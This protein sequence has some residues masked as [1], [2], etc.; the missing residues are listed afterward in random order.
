MT[1]AE[2]ADQEALQTRIRQRLG[3]GTGEFDITSSQGP[4]SSSDIEV[5][6]TAGD[7]AALST[8]ADRVLNRV[9]GL[10]SVAQA[11]SDLAASR[12]YVAVEVKARQA[13][14]AGY[15]EA[16]L[17]QLVARQTQ[18]TSIGD[19]TFGDDSLTV[20]LEQQDPP[21]TLA[22]LRRLEVP[23]PTGD[24]R[25]TDLADVRSA[26]SPTAIAT[27]DGARSATV[28]VTPAG[29]DTGAATAAVTAAVREVQLPA[30]AVASLGGVASD[31]ATAFTQLGLALLAAILIVYTIM[32]ATF[33]SLLQPLLL[34][35]SV[36]FAAT[37][38]ILLQIASASRWASPP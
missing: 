16:A 19:V 29:Q 22:A 5:D 17:A 8:A 37:G 32:V 38:A 31:Q 27:T 33:R 25:L 21:T 30:G 26:T 14:D 36:P 20:Y 15:S 23:T 12:Q 4:G 3:G 9:R 18:P 10:A 6:I 1:T 11:T 2:D 35:V 24:E 13:T 7:T 34:L 28:T